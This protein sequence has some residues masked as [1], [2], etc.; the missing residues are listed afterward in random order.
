MAAR[1]SVL[2]SVS[3]AIGPAYAQDDRSY[4]VCERFPEF[5]I[6]GDEATGRLG[7]R[8]HEYNICEVWPEACDI[9]GST[10]DAQGPRTIDFCEVYPESCILVDPEGLRSYIDGTILKDF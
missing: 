5:C 1:I 9:A 3:L 6:P 10:E 4:N 2:L 7:S 8:E